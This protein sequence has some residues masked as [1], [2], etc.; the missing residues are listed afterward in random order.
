MFIYLYHLIA[1]FCTSV[2]KTTRK[3]KLSC[4]N[5]WRKALPPEKGSSSDWAEIL[6]LQ[7]HPYKQYHSGNVGAAISKISSSIVLFCQLTL[8]SLPLETVS[9]QSSLLIATSSILHAVSNIVTDFYL[10][11]DNNLSL[12]KVS[13]FCLEC[14][15]R[16]TQKGSVAKFPFTAATLMSVV[17]RFSQKTFHLF[18]IFIVLHQWFVI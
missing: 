18:H 8:L 5:E 1:N 4:E 10:P 9:K 17:S 16:Q 11:S 2:E 7:D 13:L 15:D 14:L 12:D 6:R 3:R